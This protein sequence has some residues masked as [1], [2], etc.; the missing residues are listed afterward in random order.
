MSLEVRRE[1]EQGQ[2][3]E[4]VSREI[5][6]AVVPR[7]TIIETQT[8]DPGVSCVYSSLAALTAEG[9]SVT[10]WHGQDELA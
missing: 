5:L 1:P 10:S 7:I 3:A 8:E 2:S 6:T 4:A 9:K